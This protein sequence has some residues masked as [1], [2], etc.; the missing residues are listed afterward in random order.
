MRVP[1]IALA[2]LYAIPSFASD[3]IYLENRVKIYGG[4][5][6]VS[7]QVMK[8][9][10]AKNKLRVTVGD[11]DKLYRYDLGKYYVYDPDKKS[12]YEM[13]V[14]SKASSTPRFSIRKSKQAL[15][16]GRYVG[17]KYAVT[18]TRGGRSHTS[19]A[20]ISNEFDIDLKRF[21][22]LVTKDPGLRNIYGA[23]AREEGLVVRSENQPPGT[24]QRI[25]VDL[26]R[27]EERKIDDQIFLVPKN[28]AK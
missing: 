7:E 9:W 24:Q 14:P 12:Y 3:G 6:L 5:T 20:Y 11:R 15:T 2:L 22:E 19:I 25:V 1:L 17:T 27:V 16:V 18:Q 4:E 26:V 21:H 23:F 13:N 10:A 8:V 28:L